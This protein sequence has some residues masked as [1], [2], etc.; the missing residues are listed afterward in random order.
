MTID[1]KEERAWIVSRLKSMGKPGGDPKAQAYIGSPYP[2]LGLSSAQFKELHK[3]FRSRCPELGVS[4]VNALAKALYSGDTW[5]ERAFAMGILN[6]N[7]T[8][9]NEASW[10]LMD[11]MVDEAIGWA[12]SDGLASGPVS[13]YVYSHPSKFKEMLRWV[14]SEDY[15]RRR[16]STYSLSEFVSAGELDKPFELLEKLLYDKEFWVQRAVGTWLR[17]CWKK[18]QKRTGAFLRKHVKGLPPVTITVA[19]ERASKSFREE[20]RRK[21]KSG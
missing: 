11:V 2:A 7:M 12:L 19:T 10:K 3:E 14:K 18:D 5:E 4:E 1:V 15:W 20:L 6:R 17:E 8:V 21:S 9:L 16:A 13:A